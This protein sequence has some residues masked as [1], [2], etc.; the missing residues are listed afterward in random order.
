MQKILK[1]TQ[2]VIRL[3]RAIVD[4]VTTLALGSWPKQRACKGE[5]SLS[6]GVA[7][8]CPREYK[9]M[10]RK[11]PHTPKWIPTL[12]VGVPVDSQMFRE[13]L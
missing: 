1:F 9:R 3:I 6:L 8:S 13:W 4:F 7:F 12:G 10:W 2:N 5:P 11:N